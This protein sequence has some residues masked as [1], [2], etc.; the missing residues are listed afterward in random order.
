MFADAISMDILRID[1]HMLAQEGP[2]TGRIEGG[3][4]TEN[5]PRRC[6]QFAGIA[7]GEMGHDVHRIGGDDEHGLGGMTQNGGYH[8]V[9]DGGV[10][11][12]QFQ[13]GFAGFLGHP[14]G[15]D[16]GLTAGQVGIIPGHDPE[17]MGKRDGM[18]DVIGL[19]RGPFGE[20]VDQH[21]LTT[22]STHDQGIGSGGA[23]HTRTDNSDFHETL[24]GVTSGRS[25]YSGLFSV[26]GPWW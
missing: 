18:Q 11:T 14:G 25:G 4:R 8:L 7:G 19:G 9:E 21:N 17:G 13:A 26:L 5:T 23:D 6:A 12:Q 15:D 20:F 2:K 3:A 22:D 10:T 16:H 1:A 24:S